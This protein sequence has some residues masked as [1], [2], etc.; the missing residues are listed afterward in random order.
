MKSRDLLFILV[1]WILSLPL[2][3]QINHVNLNVFIANATN[4]DKIEVLWNV[5]NYLVK[6]GE[7]LNVKMTF[8]PDNL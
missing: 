2:E 4:Y 6:P 7:G 1:I 8:I 3:A 5:Y